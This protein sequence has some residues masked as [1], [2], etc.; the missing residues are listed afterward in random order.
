MQTCQWGHNR[1]GL[2]VRTPALRPCVGHITVAPIR[3]WATPLGHT[4]VA[5]IRGWATPSSQVNRG[6][7]DLVKVSGV[8]EIIVR[9]I[10]SVSRVYVATYT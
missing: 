3:R 9:A 4:T 8:V 2:G 5:P 6:N 1:Y 10:C 7:T